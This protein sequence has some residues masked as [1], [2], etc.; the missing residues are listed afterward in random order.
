MRSAGQIPIYRH[1]DALTVYG[2]PFETFSQLPEWQNVYRVKLLAQLSGDAE[3]VIDID[4]FDPVIDAEFFCDLHE[5]ARELKKRSMIFVG[6]T[7]GLNVTGAFMGCLYAVLDTV[8]IEEQSPIWYVRDRYKEL[9]I[10]TKAM[11]DLCCHPDLQVV[12]SWL[13][14]PNKIFRRICQ[15]ILVSH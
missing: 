3:K 2:G 15:W 9:A 5:V 4:E 13:W 12:R 1:L 10:Q 6:C 8:L 11:E 14:L 7:G